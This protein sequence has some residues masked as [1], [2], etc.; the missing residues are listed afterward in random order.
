[1]RDPFLYLTLAATL[2]LLLLTA[3]LWA[4]VLLVALGALAL[5]S[6]L[7]RR[8][9]CPLAAGMLLAAAIVAAGGAMAAAAAG[10]L[11]TRL[12]ERRLDALLDRLEADA[13]AARDRV[14]GLD[15]ATPRVDAFDRLGALT[16]GDHGEWSYLLFDRDG[17]AVAWAGEGLL[18]DEPLSRQ[19]QETGFVASYT[20]TTFYAVR[21]V[22]EG[23]GGFWILA[24]RSFSRD[25]LP[26]SAGPLLERRSFRWWIEADDAAGS[27]G[28]A[29]TAPSATTLRSGRGF[30]MRLVREPDIDPVRR[31]RRWALVALGAALL[32]S[33]LERGRSHARAGRS[34]IAAALGVVAGVALIARAGGAALPTLAL[35]LIAT[36]VAVAWSQLPSRPAP[37]TR[38]ARAV[39]GALLTFAVAVVVQRYGAAPDLGERLWAGGAPLACRLAM[40]V[41]ALAAL[42]PP[43]A[44]RVPAAVNARPGGGAA[45]GG[46]AWPPHWASCCSPARSRTTPR[47]PP[48]SSW[49]AARPAS[50]PWPS[51][52]GRSGAHG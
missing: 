12:A 45:G 23:P 25:R 41:V 8:E 1:L 50:P 28:S 4:A 39:L 3:P 20:A 18:H 37:A 14:R 40:A 44:A 52:G 27:P 30:S 22:G 24:G 47:S 17:E 9:A 34:A 6:G 26:F 13:D 10:P 49:S 32:V 7:P 48:C 11:W 43:A 46:G 51:A 21:A 36:A 16:A 19:R 38:W 31:S 35:L 2:L 15:A 33:A 29:A 42:L 5:A